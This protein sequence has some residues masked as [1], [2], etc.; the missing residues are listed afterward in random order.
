MKKLLTLLFAAGV[1]GVVSCKKET[2]NQSPASGAPTGAASGNFTFNTSKDVN[3]NVALR[4]NTNEPIA[5]A[6]VNIYEDGAETTE[7]VFKGIT[8]NSGQLN[9]KLNIAS[10]TKQLIIDPAYVGLLRNVHANINGN[11]T[12]VVIGGKT[13]LAGDAIAEAVKNRNLKVAAVNTQAPVNTQFVYPAPY[14]SAQDAIRDDIYYPLYLGIPKYME[15]EVEPISPQMLRYVNNSL[16]ESVPVPQNHPEYLQ[17]NTPTTLRITKRTDVS[18]T[19]VSEGASYQNTLAYYTYPTNNKPSNADAIAKATYI[20]PN[21]SA[22]GSGGALQS[23]NKVKLGTFE[24]GTSIGFIVLRNSWTL[25]DVNTSVARYYSENAF[26]P[27]TESSSKKHSI[28]LRDNENKHFVIGFEDI[29]RTEQECDQDFN[30]IVFFAN[31]GVDDAID[32][33]GVPPVD[34]NQDT[35]GDGVND[36]KDQY[37][38]DPERAFD[39]YYPSKTT[40]A[41]WG[42]E[43]NWPMKGDYDMNDLVINY[44]YKFVLSAKNKVVDLYTTF[45]PLAAGSSFRNGFG[46]QLPVPASAVKRVTGQ[47]FINNYITM[48]GNGVEAGQ[49]NAVIIPFDNQDAVIKNADGSYFVN[50]MPE[51]EKVEPKAFIVTIN[52]SS[53]LDRSQL[54]V[55][56]VNPFLI[57]NLRREVE[58]HLP[59]YKPTDKADKS[60]FG[61]GEDTSEPANGRYYMADS[62]LPWAISYK[63]AT[64]YAIETVSIDR[65]YNHFL[66][67]AQSMGVQYPDW[68]NVNKTGYANKSLLYLK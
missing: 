3:V 44:R 68:Y 39:D 25:S 19:F 45:K 46:V 61:T 60:L 40:Y 13:G 18:V 33:V 16:P 47:K 1:A 24:A 52:F 34:T 56:D 8:D 21:A 49:T 31:S 62:N 22:G 57:S 48:A 10:S 58:V 9:I 67:W 35:D 2:F 7:P 36:D 6:M 12:N 59:G 54:A 53:P 28:I 32:T 27:E 20:F 50:T 4:T 41:Q 30:D 15:T 42:F 17:D 11:N 23:G 66:E 43:D 26:N 63:Y 29:I 55:S 37:P 65:A 5:G 38:T 51:K 14:T 64:K